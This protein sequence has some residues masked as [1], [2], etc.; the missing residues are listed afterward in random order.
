MRKDVIGER[1]LRLAMTR[2]R[3]AATVGDLLEDS[4]GREA[5]WFWTSLARMIG[6]TIVGQVQTHIARLA[7][8]AV[9][10]FVFLATL[11]F[12]AN[13]VAAAVWYVLHLVRD[14]TGLELILP[15]DS[16]PLTVPSWVALFYLR[17]F[18]PFEIGRWAS[19]HARGYELASWCV[20]ML[21]WPVL[22]ALTKSPIDLAW[23]AS[24]SLMGMIYGRWRTNRSQRI[25]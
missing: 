13:V 14:H 21:V 18:L 3:A 5:S 25:A 9:A 11:S 17:L 1:L 7:V 16:L 6:R 19:R 15:G 8:V 20:M 24:F 12:A 4:V 23:V 10:G 2:E 22:G